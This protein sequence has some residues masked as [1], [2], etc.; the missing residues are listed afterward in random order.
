MI[1]LFEV[2]L[3]ILTLAF[4]LLHLIQT[5]E[6]WQNLLII[7]INEKIINFYLI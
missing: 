5:Q 3:R 6:M 4:V 7:E 1:Y 2:F